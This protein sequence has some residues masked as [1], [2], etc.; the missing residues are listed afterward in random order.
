VTDT[1]GRRGSVRKDP[2]RGTWY[3]IADVA[4]VGALQRKQVRRR[5]FATEREAH[6]ALTKLLGELD[7]G[8]YVSPDLKTTLTEYVE[9]TWLPSLVVRNRR[10]STLESYRRNLEVHVL[11]RLGHRPLARV[12]T[13]DLDRLY[14]DLLVGASGRRA[15]APRS[16]RYIHTIMYGVFG[17][18]VQKGHL[19][20]NPCM[21]ADAPDPK[22][23]RSRTMK[24]WTADDLRRFLVS[25]DGDRFRAPLLLLATTG[26]RR[27]EALGLKWGDLRLDQGELDIVRSLG[28]VDNRIVLGLPKTERGRRIV[29]LDPATVSALR[30]HRAEQLQERLLVGPGYLDQDWVF[31]MPDGRPVHPGRFTR[32]FDRRASAAELPRIRLH[33]LRHTWATL[34]MRAGINPKVVQERIGHASV[35]ITLDL[36]T[37]VDRETHA[38][39]AAAVSGLFL[40]PVVS[41]G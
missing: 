3:V 27:G 25:L 30:Q 4:D 19:A 23:C 8:N 13:A 16:V 15:L 11:P 41:G 1:G 9:E 24:T 17:H 38:A 26:M 40:D 10:P 22:A 20:V 39:A 34:A 21:R 36:Y 37:H 7:G 32:I 28:L 29:S 5:G 12:T 6:R 33:D 18:A 2:R 35:A 14:A 31:A